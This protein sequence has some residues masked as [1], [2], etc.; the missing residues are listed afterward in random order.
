MAVRDASGPECP[1]GLGREGQ[2]VNAPAALQQLKLHVGELK[3]AL[4][5][6]LE[7]DEA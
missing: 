2:L 3:A 7:R 5:S 4:A 1:D 6:A